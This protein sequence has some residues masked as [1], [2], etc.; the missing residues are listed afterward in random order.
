[1]NEPGPGRKPPGS[2]PKEPDVYRLIDHHEAIRIIDDVLTVF[3]GHIKG[4]RPA[5]VEISG[6][7]FPHVD[8]GGFTM[9]LRTPFQRVDLV[10]PPGCS[11]AREMTTYG[12]DVFASGKA[13][14]A[15]WDASE[16]R[17]DFLVPGPWCLQLSKMAESAVTGP[18]DGALRLATAQAAHPR[19]CPGD[20]AGRVRSD[21]R[22]LLNAMTEAE[23]LARSVFDLVTS[24]STPSRVVRF[25]IPNAIFVSA[26]VWCRSAAAFHPNPDH[27][28]QGNGPP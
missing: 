27:F 7:R 17:V 1:M 15:R 14:S 5:W 19:A 9:V 25:G 2:F 21:V 4:H 11:S 10:R 18:S 26:R 28:L 16:I 8:A 12:V 23:T 13:F 22:R 3:R 24:P 6:R 20:T